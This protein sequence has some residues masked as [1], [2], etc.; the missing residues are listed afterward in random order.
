MAKPKLVPEVLDLTADTKLGK[1]LS[2]AF[3]KRVKLDAL[4][5]LLGD[6]VEADRLPAWITWHT[7]TGFD[8]VGHLGEPLFCAIGADEDEFGDDPIGKVVLTEY[9]VVKHTNAEEPETVKKPD[10]AALTSYE[11]GGY[12][13]DNLVWAGRPPKTIKDARKLLATAFAAASGELPAYERAEAAQPKRKTTGKGKGVLASAAAAPTATTTATFL[14]NPMRTGC[15]A[16]AISKTAPKVVWSVKTGFEGG[17]EYGGSPV[18]DESLG[19][20]FAG[21]YAFNAKVS[22]TTL[23]GKTAWKRNLAKNQCWLTGDVM[24]TD[25]VLYVPCNKQL[26]ALD[27]KTGRPKWVANVTGVQGTPVVVG[28]V[29]I[30]GAGDGVVALSVDKGRKQWVFRVKRDDVSV[31]VR[32]GIAYADGVIYFIA[33]DKLFAVDVASQK[34]LWTIRAIAHATPS[35]DATCVYTW[36]DKGI[37]AVDRATGKQKWLATIANKRA[38]DEKTFAITADRL[39]T[40]A[41]GA[42]AAFDLATGK[43]QWSVVLDKPYSIGSCAPVIG[44]GVAVCILIDNDTDN[45]ALIGVDLATGK[46]LW[47]R[48]AIEGEPLSWYSTPAIANDG[49]ILVQAYSLHALK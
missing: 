47:Q 26:H 44:G 10:P 45:R 7:G 6:R 13:L 29:V 48:A 35:V 15:Y 32:A 43:A 40:R 36:T 34:K 41:A 9:G 37:L 17:G 46:T 25:G 31:G 20:V 3:V 19:L 4:V 12:L 42:L 30:Q 14:A 22:A 16:G 39:L 27:A 24:V 49:T 18:V 8:R 11:G 23:A 1:Q 28:D 33:E 21:D 5:A 2:K 38:Y